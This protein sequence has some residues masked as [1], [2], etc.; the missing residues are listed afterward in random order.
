VREPVAFTDSTVEFT[1]RLCES[2]GS[3]CAAP[4]KVAPSATLAAWSVS[5]IYPDVRGLSDMGF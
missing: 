2:A 3:I 5:S 4:W 1:I